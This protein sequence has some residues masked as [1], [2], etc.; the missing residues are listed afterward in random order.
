MFDVTLYIVQIEYLRGIHSHIKLEVYIF[1][2]SLNRTLNMSV[3]VS[4]LIWPVHL[5]RAHKEEWSSRDWKIAD[6]G[7]F[8]PEHAYVHVILVILDV[9]RVIK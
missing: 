5:P 7:R 4:V 9:S 1:D 8:R 3:R 6:I 2:I